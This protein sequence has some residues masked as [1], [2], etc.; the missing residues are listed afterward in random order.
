MVLLALAKNA[1]LLGFDVDALM[2]KKAKMRI[3]ESDIDIANR[4][5]YIHDNYTNIQSVL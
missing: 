2:M 5:E 3:R 4:I 1:R